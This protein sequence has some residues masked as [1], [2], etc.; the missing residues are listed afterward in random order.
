MR[1]KPFLMLAAVFAMAFVLLTFSLAREKKFAPTF[2]RKAETS[3]PSKLP[4][5]R[6]HSAKKSQSQSQRRV[7][8]SPNLQI[9]EALKKN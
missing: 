3:A 7:T 8:V 4:S 1:F 9:R 5:E 6:L 2:Q